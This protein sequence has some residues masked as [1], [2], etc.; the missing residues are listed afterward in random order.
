[1]SIEHLDW[2]TPCIITSRGV[3]CNNKAKWTY[4]SPCCKLPNVPICQEHKTSYDRYP[5][6]FVCNCG[7]RAYLVWN[8]LTH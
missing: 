3:P 6:E 5:E 1:M 7:N 2:D 4:T 8:L